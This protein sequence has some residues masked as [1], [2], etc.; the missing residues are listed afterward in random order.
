MEIVEEREIRERERED[1]LLRGM[2]PG[3]RSTGKEASPLLM[4]SS[5]TTFP[6]TQNQ[7]AS[8]I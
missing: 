5:Q 8:K 2:K 7:Q 4:A 1:T 3:P 6:T